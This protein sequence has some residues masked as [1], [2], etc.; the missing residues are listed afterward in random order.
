M[1]QPFENFS[2]RFHQNKI[3]IVAEDPVESI[4]LQDRSD[5]STRP[6]SPSVK[7]NLI[8]ISLS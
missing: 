1:I 8:D 3:L 2:A 6:P 7:G 4:L 5:S